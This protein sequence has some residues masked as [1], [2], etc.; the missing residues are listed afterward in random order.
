MADR[1]VAGKIEKLKNPTLKKTQKQKRK[2]KYQL[3]AI[4]EHHSEITTE[5]LTVQTVH[6]QVDGRVSAETAECSN[7]VTEPESML[8]SDDLCIKDGV[9]SSTKLYDDMKKDVLYDIFSKITPMQ[10]N[11]AMVQLITG[12]F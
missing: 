1:I 8:N 4:G 6:K 7:S 3:K 12:K 5:G 2:Q 10:E 9:E 11:H